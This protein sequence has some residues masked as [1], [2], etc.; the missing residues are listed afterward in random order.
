MLQST[1]KSQ[2]VRHNLVTEQ[3]QQQK[4]KELRLSQ[5]LAHGHEAVEGQNLSLS[6]QILLYK[7]THNN[8]IM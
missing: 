1:K 3:Q 2:R 6:A 7:T 8:R 4:V 5:L